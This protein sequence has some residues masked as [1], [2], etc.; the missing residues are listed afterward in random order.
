MNA[1]RKGLPNDAVAQVSE[2]PDR[3]GADHAEWYSAFD[4]DQVDRAVRDGRVRRVTF[5]SLDQFLAGLW[6]GEIDAA[7][8]LAAEVQVGFD[9]PATVEQSAL[10]RA[11]LTSWSAASRNNRRRQVIAGLILSAIAIAAAFVLNWA[12]GA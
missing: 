5:D 12:A 8:W 3:K 6:N 1:Q 11:V 2:R 7:A 9:E 10:S 4:L